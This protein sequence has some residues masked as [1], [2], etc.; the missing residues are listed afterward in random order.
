MKKR[1]LIIGFDSMDRILVEK[2]LDDLPNIKKFKEKSLNVKFQGVFPPDSPTS[3]A[4]IYTG[5]DPG[6][7]GIVFFIDP[8]EKSSKLLTDEIANETVRGKTFWD[9]IGKAGKKV[10]IAFPLLGYPTWQVNGT[11]VGRATTKTDVEMNPPQ[12]TKEMLST[13]DSLR[14]LPGRNPMNFVEKGREILRR[15]KE[16][17]LK[18]LKK[19]DWDLFFWYS[20]VLD[21][22]EHNFWNCF[23]K[24]DPTYVKGNEFEKIIPEFYQ[25]YDRV[26]GEFLDCVG[27]ET[28][29]ILLSDHGHTRRP[30][31]IVNVNNILMENGYLVM[32]K[33][34]KSFKTFIYKRKDRIFE[35]VSNRR[36]GGLAARLMRLI[37]SVKDVFTTPDYID[38]TKTKAHVSDLSG[39][40]A[41]TY[42]GIVIRKENLGEMGYEDAKKNVIS[43]LEDIKHPESGERLVKWAKRREDL[44]S[45]PF[46][47]KYP[48]IVF[49]FHQGYGAGWSLKEGLI[50]TTG[51]HN[52]H[53]GSHRQDSPTLMINNFD[54]VRLK[55]DSATLMDFAPTLLDL[56]GVDAMGASFDGESIVERN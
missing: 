56:M 43:I 2:F 1:V 13:L 8:L 26:L 40:K 15:E 35:M 4:S 53:P 23:D 49:E 28:S 44:Y 52:I 50:S 36:L 3:W 12:E 18:Y 32:K 31:N 22:M 29:V 11:M 6:K 38:W 47:D 5:L 37:P 54:G 14:G 27:E 7:H 41:Y 20:S 30:T 55:K 25:D 45:G 19:N 48:D 17:G 51:A 39:I 9:I 21:P 42:G 34:K 24:E 46:I 10:F 33:S 16:F